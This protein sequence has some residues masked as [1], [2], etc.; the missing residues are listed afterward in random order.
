VRIVRPWTRVVVALG[1]PGAA[2]QREDAGLV[3][4]IARRLSRAGTEDL[5]IT[6]GDV[7]LVPST[8]AGAPGVE[9]VTDASRRATAID[10]VGP[11]DLVLVPAYVVHDL[12][13]MSGWRI[14]RAL[15]DANVAVVGGP[16]R[17]V[18]ARGS[19]RRPV[20]VSLG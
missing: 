11:E 15:A 6:T 18:V 16:R 17:L 5:V 8:M 7:D 9:V 19:R 1:R 12:A 20:S 4:A 3:L 2:W 13:P 10:D 14:A